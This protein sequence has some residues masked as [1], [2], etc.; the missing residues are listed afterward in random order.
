MKKLSILKRVFVV[1]LTMIMCCG[2]STSVL[3][4]EKE[5]QLPDGGEKLE[6]TEDELEV[7]NESIQPRSPAPGLSSISIGDFSY[8][9]NNKVLIEVDIMGTAKSVLCWCNNMQCTQDFNRITSIKVGSTVVGSRRY[10]KTNISRA[11]VQSGIVLNINAQATNAVSPW[12]T[13]TTSRTFILP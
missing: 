6:L 3:A 9:E 13:M 4:A 12:D 11:E 7:L 1:A 10:F 2:A 8:D 5:E